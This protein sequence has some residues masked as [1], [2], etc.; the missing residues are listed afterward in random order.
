LNKYSYVV[1]SS[2]VSVCDAETLQP[3]GLRTIGVA[4]ITSRVEY[5]PMRS[6]PTPTCPGRTPYTNDVGAQRAVASGSLAWLVLDGAERI[7][8]QE[9]LVLLRRF[10]SRYPRIQCGI[11]NESAFGGESLFFVVCVRG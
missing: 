10:L 7:R 11:P 8:T 3:T 5:E 4:E 9:L 1:G 2:T 6:R